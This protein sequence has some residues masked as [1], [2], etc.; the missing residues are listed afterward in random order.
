M[1]HFISH[2]YVSSGVFPCLLIGC[3]MRWFYTLL[4][5]RLPLPDVVSGFILRLPLPDVVSC[6]ILRLPLP[7]VVSYF[8]LRLPLPDVVSCFILRLPLPDIVSCLILRLP[9]PD[10]WPGFI[11]CFS[12]TYLVVPASE[13][14]RYEYYQLWI[15]TS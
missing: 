7:D 6:F 9:L 12:Y 11:L 15:F 3:G 14:G 13:G 2:L 4:W 8:I 10:I 5:I 1:M